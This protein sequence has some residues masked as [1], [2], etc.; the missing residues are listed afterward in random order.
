VAE[1]L[2]LKEAM[3]YLKVSRSTIFEWCSSGKLPYFKLEASGRLSRRFRREDLDAVLTPGTPGPQ[4]HGGG[5]R[6]PRREDI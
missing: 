5:G 6:P 1:W 2:T 4:P 3:A